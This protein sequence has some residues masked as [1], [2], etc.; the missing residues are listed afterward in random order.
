MVLS[1]PMWHI[2][3]VQKHVYHLKNKNLQKP[4]SSDSTVNEVF[5]Y[6]E[7]SE[8]I[9]MSPTEKKVLRRDLI[10]FDVYFTPTF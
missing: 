7:L 3:R 2:T 5:L 4:E 10:D 9:Y 8:N 1:E 6:A